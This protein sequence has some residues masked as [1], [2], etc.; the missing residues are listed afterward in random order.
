M[1]TKWIKKIAIG[2]GITF[3]ILLILNIGLNFW[4]KYKLP[5][6]I[7]NNSDYLIAYEKLEV[8]LGT[9]NIFATQILVNNK[10]TKKDNILGV[11]GTVDTIRIKGFNIKKLIFTKKIEVSDIALTR[12]HLNIILPKAKN[13]STEKKAKPFEMEGLQIT[14]GDISIFDN[15]KKKVFSVKNLQLSIDDIQWNENTE[16]LPIQFSKFAT[17]GTHFFFGNDQYQANAS[18]FSFDENK[19]ILKNIVLKP[20]SI[21]KNKATL[22]ATLNTCSFQLENWKFNKNKLNLNTK[23]ISIEG[24]NAKIISPIKKQKKENQRKIDIEVDIADLDIK[25]SSIVLNQPNQSLSIPKI[26]A[27]FSNIKLD[28]NTM[29]SKGFPFA[30][31]KYRIEVA[32]LTYAQQFYNIRTGFIQVTP[33]EFKIQDFGL[34]PKYSR[35]QFAKLI[36]TERDLFD[37]VF[38][39]M[40]MK[41]NWDL[42]TEKTYIDASQLLINGVKANIFRTKLP[43]D[44][45]RRKP[46]YSELLRKIKFPMFIAN[47]QI[48]NSHIEY[49]EDTPKSNGPGKL[50]F[51]HFNMDIKNLNSAKI[52]GK[53]THIPIDIDCKFF[54]VSPM[55]I[56]WEMN[57]TN[58]N[59]NFTIKGNIDNLPASHINDFTVPYLKVKTLGQIQN[60][61]FDFQG[62]KNGIGGKMRL[63]HKDL[64]VSILNEKGQKKKFLSAIVNVFVKTDSKKNPEAVTVENIQR[65]PTKSF[66]NMFWKGIESGLVKTLIGE[67]AE[68]ARQD[69]QTK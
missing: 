33:K 16:G 17:D 58:L 52:K 23:N 41:G 54:N 39:S 57:T 28:E 66:F 46:L 34:K 56:H 44:D 22:D 60:L 43:P 59:D 61:N 6:Y 69:L 32:D 64:K 19:G 12:P 40:E 7:K 48:R 38:S 8:D 21:N 68:N 36:S 42:F 13:N 24:L 29:K 18:S 62:N 30:I 2:F 37:I 25:N 9:G 67:T 35:S 53:P 10:N 31:E 45:L 14:N 4:L 27:H 55:K 65:D 47:T 5:D 20:K 63:K 51:S 50:T 3:G 1:N 15:L 26:N 11:Q 49:E